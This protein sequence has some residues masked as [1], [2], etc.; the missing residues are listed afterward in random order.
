MQSEAANRVCYVSL[1]GPWPRSCEALCRQELP[2]VKTRWTPLIISWVLYLI[3]LFSPSAELPDLWFET[4]VARGWKVAVWCVREMHPSFR[5]IVRHPLDVL[6]YIW[7]MTNLFMLASPLMLLPTRRRTIHIC[8]LLM[9]LAALVNAFAFFT[10][11][12]TRFRTGYYL[13]C[14]SFALATVGLLILRSHRSGR[15]TSSGA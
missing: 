13:W 2:Y 4:K 1:N 12:E 11:G 14:A 3:A 8:A 9:G 6:W 5:E 15:T 7:P 10:L